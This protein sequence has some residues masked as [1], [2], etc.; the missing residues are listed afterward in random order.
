MRIWPYRPS[1]PRHVDNAPATPDARAVTAILYLNPEWEP[2]HGGCLRV[3][4]P[5][6]GIPIGASPAGIEGRASAASPANDEIDVPPRLGALALFWSHL[7][8]HEASARGGEK[9]APEIDA[10]V[11][12]AVRGPPR[13]DERAES[14]SPNSFNHL[15]VDEGAPS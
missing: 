4:T 14:S 10:R 15:M 5:P 6:A 13:V 8:E 7:V 3:A 9:G 2:S 11:K 12:I 1:A